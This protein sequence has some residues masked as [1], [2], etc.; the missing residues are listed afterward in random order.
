MKAEKYKQLEYISR[1]NK[2]FFLSPA[3]TLLGYLPKTIKLFNTHPKIGSPSVTI[4]YWPFDQLLSTKKLTS[5][6]NQ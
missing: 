4:F 1:W 5:F 6:M 3:K 2:T